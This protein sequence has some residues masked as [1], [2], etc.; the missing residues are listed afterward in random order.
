MK[1]FNVIRTVERTPATIEDCGRGVIYRPKEKV[2]VYITLFGYVIKLPK[3]FNV[4]FKW[5]K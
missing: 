2:D 1:L 4:F 3:I 5:S